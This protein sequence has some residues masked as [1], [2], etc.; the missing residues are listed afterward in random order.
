MIEWV[1]NYT[2]I[3]KEVGVKL[4]NEH[5]NDHVTTSGK[6]SHDGKVTMLWNQ[7]VRLAR[8]LPNNKPDII[9]SDNKQGT[10]ILID[11]SILGDRNVIKKEAEIFKYKDIIIEIQ[12]MWNVKV[13]I[14]VVI[15]ATG[16]ISISLRQ[17]LSNIPGKYE[18]KEL[19][20]IA[21][22]GTAQILREVLM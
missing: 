12:R 7:Q 2:N 19:Q 9:I 1:L 14:S 16:T 6:I 15:G 17:C 21:I 10:C 20:K 4:D 13:R 5:W 8:T 18:I 22:L 3:C 11:V